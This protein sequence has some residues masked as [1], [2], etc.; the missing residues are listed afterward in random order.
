MLYV[1]SIVKLTFISVVCWLLG[2]FRSA[3]V[4]VVVV[5]VVGGWYV[6]SSSHW[7][8]WGIVSIFFSHCGVFF[9]PGLRFGWGGALVSVVLVLVLV[10]RYFGWVLFLLRGVFDTM[11]FQFRVSLLL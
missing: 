7:V 2:G 11:S 9:F 8:V 10:L 3:V 6:V 1:S 5:C 4:V